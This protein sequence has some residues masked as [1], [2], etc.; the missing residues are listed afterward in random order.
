MKPT[1]NDISERLRV[2][3]RPLALGFKQDP[4]CS[5]A[6]REGEKAYLRTVPLPPMRVEAMSLAS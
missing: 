4:G 1:V 3:A 5:L 2:C 6:A